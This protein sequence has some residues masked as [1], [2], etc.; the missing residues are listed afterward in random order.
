MVLEELLSYYK[1]YGYRRESIAEGFEAPGLN[2]IH[3]FV[4]DYN[5]VVRIVEVIEFRWGKF[6]M[7]R[8]S[9]DR[10]MCWTIRK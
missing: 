1:V 9:E 2:R 6:C 7:T 4:K 3:G 10:C 8:I 5:L